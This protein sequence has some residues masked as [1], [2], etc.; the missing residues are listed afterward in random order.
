[1]SLFLDCATV[2][3]FVIA[4][5]N[6][7]RKGFVRSVIGLVGSIASLG[8]ALWLSYPVGN[9]ID[10]TFM[11]KYVNNSITKLATSNNTYDITRIN[12]ILVALPNAVKQALSSVGINELDRQIG[13][14]GKQASETVISAISAPLSLLISRTIAFFIIF[15]IC[16]IILGIIL[17]VLNVIFKL[18]V[19]GSVNSIAGAV[20]GFIEAFFVI[21]VLSTLLT[22]VMSFSSIGNKPPID[23]AVVESTHVYKYVSNINPLSDM[24]LKK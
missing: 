1:M 17:H 6:G 10:S 22:L 9:W 13:E 24:L 21:F 4:I 7:F 23:K 3:I 8:L 11:Q 20:V 19:L 18:P 5:V 15:I 14:V 2:A 16:L 12:G